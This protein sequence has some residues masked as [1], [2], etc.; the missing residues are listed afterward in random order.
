MKRGMNPYFVI[1]MTIVLFLPS[2]LSSRAVADEVAKNPDPG[3]FKNFMN[4]AEVYSRLC[5]EM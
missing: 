1:L 5:N 3:K 4:L 2:E